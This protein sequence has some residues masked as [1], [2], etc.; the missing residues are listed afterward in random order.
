M[1]PDVRLLFLR[2][3]AV[4]MLVAAEGCG[5]SDSGTPPTPVPA[6]APVAA[7]APA[8]PPPVT[9][10]DVAVSLS[11]TMNTAFISAMRAGS[12]SAADRHSTGAGLLAFLRFLLPQPLLA[13]SNSFQAPC[14]R[15]GNV[16][17]R[18]GGPR[19]IEY[20]LQAVS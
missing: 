2:L 9:V 10:S 13:Q 5:G 18:Y 8:P 3:I 4:A 7:P 1:D 20:N 11:N 16:V 6:P 19:A 15:G 12:P 14:P 17:V